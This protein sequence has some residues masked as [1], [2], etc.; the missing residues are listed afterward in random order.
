MK[1]RSCPTHLKIAMSVSLFT[2][3]TR[4]HR[5][6]LKTLLTGMAA[7]ILPT[8]QARIENPQ[9]PYISY[10]VIKGDNIAKISQKLLI[11][12]SE[13]T[14][15]AKL[16]GLK[17]P[18]LIQPG[19]VID[20]PRSLLK[21][22]SQPEEPLTGRLESASGDVKINNQAAKAGDPVRQGD[23]VQT[24]AL[25]SATVKLADGSKVQWMP[26]TI[27]EVT[28]QSQ[29]AMKDPAS[30]IST[31]WFSGAIRLV[32]GLLDIAADKTTRRASPLGIITPTAVVGVRGTQFRVAFDDPASG[33]ARTEVLEGKV[34]ADH[35]AQAVGSD[36]GGGFGTAIQPKDREIRVVPLLPALEVALLP[37]RILRPQPVASPE[38]RAMWQ[39]ATLAG[40]SG[41]KAEVATDAEF[42]QL[43]LLASATQPQFDVS[44]LPNGVYHA[45]VRGFDAQ[46]IEGY[47]AVRRIEIVDAPLP[48]PPPR[49]VVWIH[50]IGIAA[51]AFAQGS[52]VVLVLSRQSA[53]TPARL[54]LEI[55]QDAGMT[56]ALRQLPVDERGRVTLSQLVP[57]TSAF[58]RISS[59]RG[60]EPSQSSP[61]YRLMLP[62]NW[63][64]TV[65][66]LSDAL[67][68][69]TRF[70]P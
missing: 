7:S 1:I 13:F 48:P 65:L 62:D 16:N 15:L 52:D 58:V 31:T 60:L 64:H 57:G 56:Q 8:V 47:N 19:T 67:I 21:L 5:H 51:S 26:R 37:E 70:K 36:V 27:A 24:G 38:S 33:S 2:P 12:P 14:Q 59:I 34:R 23:R 45:R 68:P 43:V 25:S 10:T 17:N 22:G 11:S 49:P 66:S 69:T 40:A 18:A 4:L 35:P 63:G 42:T 61:V 29:Y 6:A 30:S 9:E 41:Y 39:L 32:E 28:Q 44:S 53:D 55:A 46:K 20:V 50:H 3:R 54:I